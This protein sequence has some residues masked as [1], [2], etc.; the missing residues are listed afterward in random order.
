[1]PVSVLCVN[2]LIHNVL[3]YLTSSCD[4]GPWRPIHAVSRR[5]DTSLS[6]LC[7]SHDT[8]ASESPRWLNTDS[9]G[10]TL[11]LSGAGGQGWGLR[12]CVSNK[13]SAF[14]VAGMGT[15]SGEPPLQSGKAHFALEKDIIVASG[16]LTREPG[17]G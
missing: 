9:G 7:G 5:G 11:E 2:G 10:S 14:A 1:L 17:E 4:T 8:G 13:F 15:T 16:S 12:I 3:S 6:G